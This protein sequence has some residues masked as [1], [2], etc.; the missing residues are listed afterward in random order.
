MVLHWTKIGLGLTQENNTLSGERFGITY[1]K[2][3]HPM[4]H[5]PYA[6]YDKQQRAVV[7]C[8]V[9]GT[10]ILAMLAALGLHTL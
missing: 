3:S 8:I 7:A 6:D 1:S 10:V 4:P 5:S 2:P 9:F